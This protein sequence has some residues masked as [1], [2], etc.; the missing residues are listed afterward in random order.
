[1]VIDETTEIA[2]K[3]NKKSH[4]DPSDSNVS[5]SECARVLNMPGF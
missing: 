5:G 1:M 2:K 3:K 4:L